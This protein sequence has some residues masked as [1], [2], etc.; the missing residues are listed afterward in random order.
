MWKPPRDKSCPTGAR[1]A[2]EIFD[3]CIC[4]LWQRFYWL[5]CICISPYVQYS[6][7]VCSQ[8]GCVQSRLWWT[9]R[10]KATLGGMKSM[11]WALRRQRRADSWND[12]T[13]TDIVVSVNLIIV[14]SH[15]PAYSTI[16]VVSSTLANEGNYFLGD[17]FGDKGLCH[18]C[19]RHS[20]K[21]IITVTAE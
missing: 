13:H 3:I 10:C 6:I 14:I 18:W 5:G 9:M 7:N 20:V 12:E 1:V 11:K 19:F 2:Y 16:P 4:S 17:T 21:T 8:A 15:V